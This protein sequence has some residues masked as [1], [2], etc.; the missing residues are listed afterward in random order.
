MVLPGLKGNIMEIL[1]IILWAASFAS[2]VM[3]VYFAV[4]TWKDKQHLWK[5]WLLV[6]VLWVLYIGIKVVE[7]FV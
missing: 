5:M 3:W 7:K 4:Q 2:F 1:L 6:A